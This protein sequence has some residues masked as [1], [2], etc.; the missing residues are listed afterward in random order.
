M[1]EGSES[2]L[3]Q[4]VLCAWQD[5]LKAT[6]DPTL[7]QHCLAQAPELLPS[8]AEHYQELKSL[9]RSVRRVLQRHW[10]RSLAGVALLLALGVTPA[11]AAT[12]KVGDT[13]TL[14]R[15]II[16]ANTNTTAGG[17]CARGRGPDSIVLPKKK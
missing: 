8:F 11:F 13:C 6:G 9:R 15:A 16:A 4:S 5:E 1:R 17:R 2:T 12:I 10:K 7:K 14:A 3:N